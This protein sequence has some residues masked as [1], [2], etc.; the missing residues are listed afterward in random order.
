MQGGNERLFSISAGGP[1]TF[2]D[3]PYYAKAA[4]ERLVGSRPHDAFR[5]ADGV[6]GLAYGLHSPLH[7]GHYRNTTYL[8]MLAVAAD[9]DYLFALDF[10]ASTSYL[11]LGAKAVSRHDLLWSESRGIANRD[12]QYHEF[13][14]FDMSVCGETVMPN[15]AASWP[16]LFDS[17]AVCLTLPAE[18]FDATMRWATLPCKN[19][20]TNPCFLPGERD[21]YLESLPELEFSLWLGGAKLRIPLS[22]LLLPRTHFGG[23]DLSKDPDAGKS[24]EAVSKYEFLCLR[25]SGSMGSKYGSDNRIIFGAAAMRAFYIAFDLRTATIGEA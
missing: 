2:S 9:D 19:G 13:Q 12:L 5:T 15:L 1:P 10:R 20:R 16:V 8:N 4:Q 21:D 6:L 18:I 25:R 7:N 22:L 17:G 11:H 3:G 14:L 23:E 24:T